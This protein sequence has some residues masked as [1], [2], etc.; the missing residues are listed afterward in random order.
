MLQRSPNSLFNV[1][2]YFNA[3]YNKNI[4][5]YITENGWAVDEGL[6][7]DR[8]AN[9]RDNLEGVLDS[10]DAGIRVKGFMAWTL[11]D[12]YEWISGFR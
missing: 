6:E 1:L 4:T 8:I 3:R 2:S 12:N 10:L 9:Y 11:M 7:G 5:Y